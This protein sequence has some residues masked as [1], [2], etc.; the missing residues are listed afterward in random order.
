[1]AALSA[2]SHSAHEKVAAS[3]LTRSVLVGRERELE[4]ARASLPVTATMVIT[5]HCQ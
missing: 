3:R 4:V 2:E 5:L 1:M